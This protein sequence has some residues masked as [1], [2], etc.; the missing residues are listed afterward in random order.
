MA[1]DEIYS[2]PIE[3]SNPLDRGDRIVH[4]AAE[5]RKG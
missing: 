2:D 3:I 4:I 1:V 5:R